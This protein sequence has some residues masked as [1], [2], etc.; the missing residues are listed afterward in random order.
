MN[1]KTQ[2]TTKAIIAAYRIDGLRAI[3]LTAWICYRDNCGLHIGK[4]K[5]DAG[6]IF[7]LGVAQEQQKQVKIDYHLNTSANIEI[8]AIR[9]LE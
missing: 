3:N 6:D 2:F 9:G 8:D 5:I 7:G 1:T 4:Y